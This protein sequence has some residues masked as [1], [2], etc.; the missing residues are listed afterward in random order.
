[1]LKSALLCYLNLVGD[2][3]RSRFKINPY[4]PC[5]M[6]NIV[7][8]EQITV[9]FHMDDLKVSH[10]RDKAITKLIDYL[11]GIY[12]V[13]KAVHGDVHD[14]LGMRLDYSTKGQL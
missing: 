11:S 14:Y 7:G 6:S 9:L 1:M 3:T 2:L 10:K 5:V 4:Y 8:R 12:P 13:I